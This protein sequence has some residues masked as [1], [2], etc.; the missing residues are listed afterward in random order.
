MRFGKFGRPARDLR[1]LRR[2]RFH[3]LY[4]LDIRTSVFI[5]SHHLYITYT[6]M[7]FAPFRRILTSRAASDVDGTNVVV[8]DDLV[9]IAPIANGNGLS[10]STLPV[11]SP[12]AQ[13]T[14]PPARRLPPRFRTPSILSR[15][16]APLAA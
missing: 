9:Q 2:H 6:V 14:T 16:L 15:R 7:S 11:G 1:M 13:S 4:D 10:Q 3:H 8:L 12:S 5:H